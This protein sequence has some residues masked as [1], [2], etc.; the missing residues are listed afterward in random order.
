MSAYP[1]LLTELARR[2]WSDADLGKLTWHNALRVLRVTEDGRAR[3]LHRLQL[4]TL[5]LP[6]DLQTK[7]RARSAIAAYRP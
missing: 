4:A 1:N 2:G 3:P 5:R 6:D 7:S